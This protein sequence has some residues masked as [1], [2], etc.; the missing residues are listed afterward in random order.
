MNAFTRRGLLAATAAVATTA[1][2][3]AV[4]AKAKAPAVAVLPDATTMADLIRRK[5]ITPLEAVN[6]AIARA[7]A[8]QPK[9]NFM[10]S[11]LFERAVDQARAGTAT[12]PFAGVPFLIKDLN[13]YAGA[14]TRNGS[15]AFLGSA[16]ATVSEPLVQAFG[17][18]G[19][20]V[21]GKSATPEQG[22]L[23]TTEPIAFGPTRNP[24]NLGHSTGGSSG[25]AAAAVA[26]GIVPVAHASDGGGSIRIP[27][28][29]CGLFG[30]KP[31]RGRLIGTEKQ[32]H[33]YD[34]GVEHVL[35]RSVRDSAALFAAT[36]ITGEA[37]RYPAVGLVTGPSRR[38][39]R[40]GVLLE[41]AGGLKPDAEVQAG[42]DATVALLKG[43][44]HRVKPA[45]W[46]LDGAQFTQ[47]FLTLWSTDA[48]AQ[49]QKVIKAH[50]VSAV[51]DLLEPF[52]IGMAEQVGRLPK[53]AVETAIGRLEATVP[54]YADWFKA[55]DLILTPVLA[56]PA[57]E[58]G[59]VSPSVPFAELAARVTGYVGYT[60]V[61]NVT[62]AAAMSVPLHWTADGIPVGMQ[63]AGRAGDE[64]ILFELAYELEQ[65][66][67]WA[68]R[69]PPVWFGS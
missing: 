18:A 31:S 50:G 30:L 15:R 37:A 14:P 22:Y 61:Q 27:A 39:L 9:L 12:G 59:Y 53:G 1:Q 36:E 26:A 58:L 46:P 16:N 51:P 29:N 11:S 17:R 8:A 24:W 40:I 25:G 66:Q 64:R 54:V 55:Y 57:V 49:V 10:V 28:A 63:F 7:E 32:A 65:A 34:L 23:P 62:G 20:I 21:I 5:E 2:A 41:T 6:S 42:F 69:K 13:D 4:L 47:D 68:Q 52:T 60:P 43:L 19:L 35:S 3:S 45:R 56:K 67:P 33:A 44:G 48:A 38:R